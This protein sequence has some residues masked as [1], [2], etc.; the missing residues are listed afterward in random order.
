MQVIY[1]LTVYKVA[2]WLQFFQNI[3]QMNKKYAMSPKKLYAMRLHFRINLV[4]TNYE[5]I[6]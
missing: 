1:I 2:L 5:Y 3:L 4:N 6:I